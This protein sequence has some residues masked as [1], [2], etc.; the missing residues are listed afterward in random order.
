[1]SD[2]SVDLHLAEFIYRNK[3]R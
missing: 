2:N 1:M 3:L